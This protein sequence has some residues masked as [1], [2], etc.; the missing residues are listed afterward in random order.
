M[1][2]ACHVCRAFEDAT[3]LKLKEAADRARGIQQLRT[4]DAEQ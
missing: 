4:E 3:L 1:F 2:H